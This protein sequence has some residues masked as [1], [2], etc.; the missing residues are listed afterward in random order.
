MSRTA[1]IIDD[2]PMIREVVRALGHW[3]ELGI[4]VVGEAADGEAGLELINQLEPDIVITDVKMPRLDGLSLAERLSASPRSPQIIIISGYDDFELVRQ[5]L[6][7]GV[8]DYLLKP[9]KEAE[10]NEQLAES[11][12]RA[13][14]REKRRSERERWVSG[15]AG[16]WLDYLRA[17]QQQLAGLLRSGSVP[18]LTE[19]FSH[20]T[21]A[22]AAANAGLPEAVYCYY[23]LSDTLRRFAAENGASVDELCGEGRFGYVFGSGDDIREVLSH[24]CWLYCRAAGEVQRRARQKGRLDMGLVRR[25]IDDNSDENLSLASVAEHFHVSREYLSRSFKSEFGQ[26]FSDYLSA[27]RM[28]RARELIVDYNVPIK[29]AWQM[30]HFVD[31]THFYKC[32]KRHFGKTPGEMRSGSRFDNRRSHD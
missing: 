10:L 30:L 23:A 8:S 1:V 26:S 13:A 24:V 18:A 11:A 20:L 16:P 12:R 32:F 15:A 4:E 5:A 29:D 19:A 17:A 27:V 3:D 22:M 14:A 21:E 25:F 31:Q 2:E 9:I 7:C 6:K 28:E